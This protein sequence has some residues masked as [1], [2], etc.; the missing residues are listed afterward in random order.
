MTTTPPTDT[1]IDTL[2][3]GIRFG[4]LEAGQ[5]AI[6]AIQEDRFSKLEKGL[7]KLERSTSTRFDKLEDKFT[8]LQKEVRVLQKSVWMGAGGLGM[9]ML[10]LPVVMYFLP[11]RHTS[12]ALPKAP[13]VTLDLQPAWPQ[14]MEAATGRM[15]THG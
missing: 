7:D 5:D 1:S 9:A 6:K 10:L 11:P 4:R 8:G 2:N 15:I 13:L 12:L 3:L 14:P